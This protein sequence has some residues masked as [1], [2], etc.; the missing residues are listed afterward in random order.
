MGFTFKPEL[1]PSK[2]PTEIE[3]AWSAGVFEGEG[4]IP[5]RQPGSRKWNAAVATIV[6]KDPE[7]LYKMRDWFGGRVRF[8]RSRTIPEDQQCFVLEISGNN[9]R[10]FLA[11]IYR[12]MSTRRKSQVDRTTT[13]TFLQ[14]NSPEVMTYE[15]IR[16]YLDGFELSRYKGGSTPEEQ[17]AYKNRQT[18]ERRS[19]SRQFKKSEQNNLQGMVN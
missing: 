10:L 2:T 17:R 3:V 19:L 4:C 5:Q 13:F 15:E 16:T 8:M 12:F 18:R 14:G 1:L 7:I 6:Q 9:A 11:R